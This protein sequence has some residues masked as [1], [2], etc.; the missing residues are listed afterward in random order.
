MFGHSDSE[1]QLPWRKLRERYR[2]SQSH[3]I[4]FSLPVYGTVW[5]SYTGIFPNQHT[6]KFIGFLTNDKSPRSPWGT[7]FL[8][9]DLWRALHQQELTVKDNFYIHTNT[10]VLQN[11]LPS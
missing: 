4:P 11:W 7:H 9:A 3:F 10:V 2:C 6:Y 1:Y 8:P 5:D